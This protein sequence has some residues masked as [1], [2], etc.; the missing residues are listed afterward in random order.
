V[1]VAAS[2]F[3]IKSTG[4]CF[5]RRFR[6]LSTPGNTTAYTAKKPIMSL[7]GQKE[8]QLLFLKDPKHLF[9]FRQ[10]AGF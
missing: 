5:L 2:R 6:Y 1:T 7:W 8:K 3:I 9:Y 4:D 10:N